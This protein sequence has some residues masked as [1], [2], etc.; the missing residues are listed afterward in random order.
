MN[1]TRL[2]SDVHTQ[3]FLLVESCK[4][5]NTLTHIPYIHTPTPLYKCSVFNNL[6]FLS[7]GSHIVVFRG[8]DIWT[9]TQTCSVS[10]S[11]RLQKHILLFRVF[12]MQWFLR[13]RVPCSFIQCLDLDSIDMSCYYSI[14]QQSVFTVRPR[15]E[16]SEES[17]GIGPRVLLVPVAVRQ[18]HS[19]DLKQNIFITAWHNENEFK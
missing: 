18:P 17:T 4:R 6:S 7:A 3:Y 16:G 15:A 9:Q 19:Q 11:D 8:T 13:R 1:S 2:Y 12:P 10:A 5:H 14:S